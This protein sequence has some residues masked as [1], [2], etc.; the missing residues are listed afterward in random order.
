MRRF[1]AVPVLPRPNA[2]APTTPKMAS[3]IMTDATPPDMTPVTTLATLL[4]SFCPNVSNTLNEAANWLSDSAEFHRTCVSI[5]SMV[6]MV[7][8]MAFDTLSPML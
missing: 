1:T 3:T 7:R 8:R 5:S 6:G 4:S 2:A